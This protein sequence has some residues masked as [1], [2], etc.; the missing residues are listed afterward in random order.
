MKHIMAAVDGSEPSYRALK[1]AANL[2]KKINA[3][4]FVIVVRE[5]IVG[6]KD[7]YLV[8]NNDEIRDIK[9]KINEIVLAAQEPTTNV[10]LVKSK[11]AAFSILD[12]AIEKEVDLIVM[13]ASGKGGIGTFFLGSVSQEVLKKSACP[14]TIVH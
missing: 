8:K 14:V 6:R 3:E 5:F 7:V 2:A 1:H 13:G 10:I 4:L 9:D 12:V 11:T